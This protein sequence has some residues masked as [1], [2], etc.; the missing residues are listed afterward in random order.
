MEVPARNYAATIYLVAT[1]EP[2]L[3]NTPN[4]SHY[5]LTCGR[6]S[7]NSATYQRLNFAVTIYM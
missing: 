3:L 7:A 5:L 1:A 2:A 6:G 4:N